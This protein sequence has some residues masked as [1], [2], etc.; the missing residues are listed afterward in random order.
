[1]NG[2]ATTASWK[3]L[4]TPIK[5]K[6][7]DEILREV[8]AD[9]EVVLSPIFV[10]DQFKDTHVKVEGRFC[11][12]R[13]VVD[14]LSPSGLHLDNWEVVKDRYVVV[15]NEDIYQRAESVVAAYNGSAHL[16]S[17]GVLD[18]GRKFFVAISTGSLEIIGSG[19]KDYIDNYLVIV[20]SHD[21]SIPICYYNLDV[22]RRNNSVY[23]FSDK[24]LDF[25]L[26]KRHTPNQG[27]N[28]IEVSEAMN[29]RSAWTE[30]FK[31]VM[32][33]MLYPISTE[34]LE[35]VVNTQWNP[36][37]TSSKNQ[38]EHAEQVH[39]QIFEIY[40]RDYNSGLFGF[41][42]WSAFNAICEY[43][44]FCR[45]IPALEA[46][47]HSLEIDNYSHRLKVSLFEE[48]KKI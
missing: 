35:R 13:K 26:R 18:E 3:A 33:Q 7:R 2:K 48:L 37:T 20:T 4:A 25:N 43:V 47:Q 12:G 23:R 39:E 29:M 22:R 1:M 34:Q 9:Y 41:S 21:G 8:K 45:N 30:L 27:D 6:T 10:Y 46:A 38:R 36:S 17:C 44:D 5:S 19:D 11:T 15:P 31:S 28:N 14:G 42:K 24:S 32:G 40:R 16:D